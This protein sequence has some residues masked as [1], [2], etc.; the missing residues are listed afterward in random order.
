MTIAIALAIFAFISFTKVL[1]LKTRALSSLLCFGFLWSFVTP[2]FILPTVPDRVARQIGE[3]PLSVVYRKP[4]F[5]AE[6]LERTD[7]QVVGAHEIANRIDSLAGLLFI[8]ERVVDQFQLRSKVEILERW[9]VW[10]KSRRLKHVLSAINA[11]SLGE[12]Q[13]TFLLV[14]IKP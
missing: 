7:I 4:Y 1:S 14:R 5:I 11:S 6:A 3:R 10:Q 8:P 2:L 12:L 13:E 9:R